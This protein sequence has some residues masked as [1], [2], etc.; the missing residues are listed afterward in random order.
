MGNAGRTLACLLGAMQERLLIIGYL[1]SDMMMFA[2]T[3]VKK[4]ARFWLPEEE[5]TVI[6]SGKSRLV[7]VDKKVIIHAVRCKYGED[8]LSEYKCSGEHSG[9]DDLCDSHILANMCWD[10]LIKGE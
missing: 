3:Q 8:Y 6:V 4:E 1:E 10:E 2:P 9:L 5:Q 7:K